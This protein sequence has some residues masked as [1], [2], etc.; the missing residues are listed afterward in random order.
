MEVTMSDA[1]PISYSCPYC[2]GRNIET[3][4]KAP[5][6]RGFVLA[7]QIGSKSYIGCA[8][9]VCVYPGNIVSRCSLASVTNTFCSLYSRWMT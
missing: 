6:V 7:Y 2:E 3:A 1:E 9:C 5:Y 8:R 4:A